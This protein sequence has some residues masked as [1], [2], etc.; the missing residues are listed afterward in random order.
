ME[1]AI[2]RLESSRSQGMALR[3]RIAKDLWNA[4][5]V[6]EA[7]PHLEAITPEESEG[8]PAARIW[9]IEES[10]KPQTNFSLTGQQRFTQLSRVVRED[11]RNARYIKRYADALLARNRQAEAE[12][13][14]KKAVVIEPRYAP[15]LIQVQIFREKLANPSLPR[16]SD[17]IRDQISDFRQDMAT[18]LKEDQADTTARIAEARLAGMAGDYVGAE[19]SLR[20]GLR[21]TVD[22]VELRTTLSSIYLAQAQLASDQPLGHVNARDFILKALGTAPENLVAVRQLTPFLR[23]NSKLDHPSIGRALAYWMQKLEEDDEEIVGHIVAVAILH[24]ASG[25][26]DES[27]RVLES[28]VNALPI[29][30]SNLS[31]FLSFAGRTEKAAELAREAVKEIQSRFGQSSESNLLVVQALIEGG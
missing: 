1:L 15:D 20:K 24:C 16:M 12:V 26:V 8:F 23:P 4:E 21:L 17:E 18:L 22:S 11:P 3:F 27:I 31:L 10:Q 14:L 6:E 7:R 29:L 28:R 9:L 2:A 25:R 19:Q 30:R 5:R 13:N